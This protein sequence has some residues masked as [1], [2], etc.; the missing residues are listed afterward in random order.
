MFFS[1]LVNDRAINY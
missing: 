1:L